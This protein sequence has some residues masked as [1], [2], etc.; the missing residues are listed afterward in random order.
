MP[1]DGLAPGDAV[2]V[3]PKDK[4]DDL[5]PLIAHLRDNGR[6]DLL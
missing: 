2:L 1:T 5:K 3:C 4:A 6:A